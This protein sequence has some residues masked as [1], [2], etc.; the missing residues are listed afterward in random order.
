M[1]G[2]K[3]TAG[4][5]NARP[6]AGN[7]AHRHRRL[8]LLALVLVGLAWAGLMQAA[9]ANQNAHFALLTALDHR[10]PRIDRYRNWTGDLSY[11]EGHYYIAKAPGLALATFP[12][13]LA[14]DATG[15]TVKGPPASVPWPAAQSQMSP[16]AL[17]EVS[18]IGATLPAFLLLVLVR[19]VA[20][21]LVP[22][23]GTAAA[24]AVGTASTLAVLATM[25]F[26]HSLSACLGFA[27]FAVLF[28]ERR[29]P[30]RLRLLAAAGLLAGLAAVVEF[31]L[32]I[33]ALA[34][35]I[36]G[37]LRDGRVRRATAYAGGFIVGIVPLLAFNNWAFGSP[38][39]LAYTDVIIQ[40]GRSGHDV[41]GANSSGFFGVGRPSLRAGA[42]LLF[43]GHGLLVLSP[44][45][46]LA[47]LGF[48]SLWR[49]GSRAEAAAGGGV[50]AG[51][52]L[53]DA[54]YYLPFGGFPAGPR[55]LVPSLPFLALGV[56][57]AWRAR[58]RLT[59][60]L[61]LASVAV[62]TAALAGQP[63]GE[64]QSAGAWF[65]RLERGDATETVFHWISGRHAAAEVLPIVLLLAAAVAIGLAVT[66]G[67]H[68]D[69]RAAGIAVAT[70][71][72]WRIV[73]TG[74]PTMLIVDSQ[75]RGWAGL[76]GVVGLA[77]AMPLVFAVAQYGTA[78]LLPA[79]LL[80]PVAWPPFAAHT[81]IAFSTIAVATGALAVSA[82]VARLRRTPSEQ[83]AQSSL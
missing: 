82:Y 39:R 4:A 33:V 19:S 2:S 58:P 9:G 38:T 77:I 50:A 75:T 16:T 53:Y 3:A 12:W 41:V 49:A 26:A 79:L 69:V 10:T 13:F 52:L 76:A 78:A 68:L 28:H 37:V 62:T 60:T 11:I 7:R 25:F 35:G 83:S 47:V 67:V 73:Y 56:A 21:R 34:V 57:A 24:L 74:A 8:G 70:L 42:D 27:A 30:P 65:H 51:F 18:L 17:W 54:S 23:Y 80:V 59:V 31:P 5:A 61:F 40:R 22:G 55:F 32:A 71:V 63:Q 15:L 20:E 64:S 66:P 43:A 45:L 46:A 36:Y 48:A 6:G 1:P 81:G 72:A 44:V 29:G 14:L